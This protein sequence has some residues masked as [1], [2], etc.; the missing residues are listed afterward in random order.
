MEGQCIDRALAAAFEK[1]A[2]TRD[3]AHF[4]QRPRP[5]HPHPMPALLQAADRIDFQAPLA[6]D[7]AGE[8]LSRPE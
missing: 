8:C 3:S 2:A 5:A 1:F 7:F 4:A 6:D